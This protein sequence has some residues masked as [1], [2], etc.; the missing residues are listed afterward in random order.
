MVKISKY[1]L[2]GA[3]ILLTIYF[4]DRNKFQLNSVEVDKFYVK[5]I[6][7]MDLNLDSLAVDLN[8]L[9][10][11]DSLDL[12]LRRVRKRNSKANYYYYS[13]LDTSK[14]YSLIYLYD[15]EGKEKCLE[16]INFEKTKKNIISSSTLF[17]KGG[18][19]EDI[20]LIKSNFKSRHYID[21]E[22][23]EGYF[24]ETKDDSLIVSSRYK[25]KLTIDTEGN[26]RKDTIG[27]VVN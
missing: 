9:I 25:I 10:P 26:I 6:G 20:F 22:I 15:N 5:K 18:D 27:N 23:I 19:A 3:L 16:L 8:K 2:V 21:Q 24:S 1:L 7:F 14:I 12:A 4:F 13:I 17:C 11:V